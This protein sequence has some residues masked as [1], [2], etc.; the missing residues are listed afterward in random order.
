MDKSMIAYCG[1]YCEVC[2]WK[3]IVGC[4]GCKACASSMFWG[5]CDKAKCCIGKGLEHCG[6]C[7]VMPC[8]K[9]LA[10]FADPEHGDT[11]ERLCNLQNWA[12]GYY[13][14]ECFENDA[15]RNAKTK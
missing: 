12:K 3:D 8:D 11:G 1:T 7:D 6:Q 14:Y 10:L 5:E 9:L 2:E 13:K 15:Q 4:S